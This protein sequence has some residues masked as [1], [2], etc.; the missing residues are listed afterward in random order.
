[1]AHQDQAKIILAIGILHFTIMS[2]HFLLSTAASDTS[3]DGMFVT[4][5][6]KAF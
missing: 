1:M 4:L 3:A 6:K 5:S 2:N